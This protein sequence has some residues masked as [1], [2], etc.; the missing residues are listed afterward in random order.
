LTS[1]T[2][3]VLGKTQRFA[4]AI[5]ELSSTQV[6][7]GQGFD[8]C[9]PPSLSQMQDW[10]NNSP[11]HVWNL[12]IGGSNRGCKAA[13]QAAITA[14]FISQLYQQGWQFIPTWVGLQASCSSLNVYKMSSDPST[15]HSQGIAEANAASDTVANLGFSN[16]IVYFDL[17]YFSSANTACLAAAQA[18]IS[19]WT[20]QLHSRGNQAAV[21]GST[22]GAGVDNYHTIANVPDAIWPALWDKSGYDSLASVWGVP[23]V[24]DSHWSNHQRIRQYAG[25]H[26]EFWGS[27]ILNIDSDVLDGIVAIPGANC[28]NPNPDSNHIGLYSEVNYCGAYTILGVGDYSNASALGITDDS[29]SSIKVGV[30]VKATLCNDDNHLGACEDFTTDDSYLGDNSIGDNQVSSVKVGKRLELVSPPNAANVLSRR[31]PFDWNDV[32]GASGY[33]IQIARTAAFTT[34]VRNV[35]VAPSTYTPATDLPGGIVLYW[36]VR[37]KVSGVYRGWS[38]VRRFRT[39]NPP[40]I[41][42]L[43]MPASGALLKDYT[44]FLDWYNSTLPANA[45][46]AFD[47]YELQ[48][49]TNTS[50]T[51]DVL[52]FTTAVGNRTASSYTIPDANSLIPN[53]TY[54][55]HVRAYNAG[56]EYSTW[57][58]ARKFRSAILPPSLLSP[59]DVGPVDSRRPVFDWQDV[60]GASA[61]KIQISRTRTFGTMVMQASVVPSTVT[62][63]TNLPAGTTLYWR[64]QAAGKN[65]PSYWSSIWQFTTP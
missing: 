51:T 52:S 45:V 60:A 4:T 11:Y 41:P 28:G 40:S 18:F 13:N 55:W 9:V 64:V 33:K 19:G 2:I 36:R 7:I 20:A 54:Y 15:A 14:L 56:G 12:Y 30:D 53:K 21:Y 25:G 35:T 10:W 44:P 6:F 42:V 39:G 62:P 24:P 47:H 29:V 38:E 65:G 34:L 32:P 3:S 23:C 43:K 61:Y 31:P 37:A 58:A 8:S 27:T 17:E 57:S 1:E 63:G 50:F 26:D 49:A 46:L 22:C 16:T 59:S 48:L 5:P